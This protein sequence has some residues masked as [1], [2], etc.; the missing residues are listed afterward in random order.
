V[1]K[2]IFFLFFLFLSC[3]FPQDYSSIKVIEVIDGDTI[4][5]SNGKLVRY[6]GI[7]TPEVRIKKG[8]GFKYLP[9]P[10]ALEAKEYNRGLV[11]GKNVRIEFDLQKTDRYGRLLGYCFIEDTF[12]NAELVKEG[13]AV[14][15]TYPPNI[16]YVDLLL[17][18]Q[19]EARSQKKGLW[20][21]FKTISHTEAYNYLNQVKSVRGRVIDTYQSSK[22]TFLNFGNDYKTDFTIVIFKK[23]LGE[24][25]KEGIDPVTYY[26]NKV[27]MATGR[28][29]EYNG[30][31]IIAN[32][33][34]QI[35]VISE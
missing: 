31:E 2:K 33:P 12:I 7:D 10:F 30:P 15:Y 1:I 8:D 14:I 16:K 4:R 22:C 27:V 28:I 20:E 3:S 23:S 35:E 34:Y 21:D 25:T 29:K 11:E 26:K 5:L 9:Q 24:F 19:K 6:V 32:S 13:Y 18:L 17:K